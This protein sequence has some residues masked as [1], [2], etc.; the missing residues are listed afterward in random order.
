MN[1]PG[2]SSSKSSGKYIHASMVRIRSLPGLQLAKVESR[3]ERVFTWVSVLSYH[4][5]RIVF[6]FL[7][8]LKQ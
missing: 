3:L 4:I 2:A 5:W 7:V 8:R 6:Y 1:S